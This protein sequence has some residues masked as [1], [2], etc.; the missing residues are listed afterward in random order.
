[1]RTLTD[2]EFQELVAD[3]YSESSD[4]VVGL[5]EVAKVVEKLIETG[6]VAREQSLR[7]VRA[8]LAK[9]LL[10]GDP[11][12]SANGYKP[13]PDQNPERVVSRIEAEWLELGHTPSI[14][15]IAWFGRPGWEC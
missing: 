9:G 12:Y 15:D 10:V 6:D 8:L 5:W 1:M 7:I 14:P 3:F 4:D 13:W 2:V 11:P